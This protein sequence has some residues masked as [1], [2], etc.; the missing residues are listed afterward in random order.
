[1]IDLLSI[2]VI[3]AVSLSA[4]EIGGK[5]MVG[6]PVDSWSGSPSQGL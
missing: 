5:T 4:T 1:M 6:L 2:T 3:D